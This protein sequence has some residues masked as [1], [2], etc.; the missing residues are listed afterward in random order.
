[1]CLVPLPM[2]DGE[3]KVYNSG[4]R[5]TPAPAPQ[6]NSKRCRYGLLD[7]AADVIGPCATRRVIVLHPE[8]CIKLLRESTLQISISSSANTT[9]TELDNSMSVGSSKRMTE[10]RE[11][12]SITDLLNWEPGAVIVRASVNTSSND[13]CDDLGSIFLSCAL[14]RQAAVA[15]S[16]GDNHEVCTSTYLDLLAD[17]RISTSWLRILEQH[18]GG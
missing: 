12:N 10:L 9:N 7:E 5:A 8:T 4:R 3:S 1:M 16:K 18:L 14:R 6:I 2:K 13:D 15:E 17:E 11:H